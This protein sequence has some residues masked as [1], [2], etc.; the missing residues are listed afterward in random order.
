MTPGRVSIRVPLDALRFEQQRL[1]NLS[2]RRHIGGPR[3]DRQF[4]GDL[5]QPV[6]D[7]A[8]AGLHA[9]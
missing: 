9:P 4:I 7:T 6:P 5:S 1:G 2:F 3:K 8:F